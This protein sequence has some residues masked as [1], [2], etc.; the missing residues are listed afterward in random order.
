[1]LSQWFIAFIITQCLEMPV[2]LAAFRGRPLIC[3]GASAITHPIIWFVFPLVIP[4]DHYTL[5]LLAAESFAVIIEAFYLH[6]FGLKKALLW[7]L[8]ANSIS[9]LSGLIYYYYMGLL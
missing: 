4:L 7:S 8:L 6:F 3:F 2:Y 9:F 1:M 5:Y